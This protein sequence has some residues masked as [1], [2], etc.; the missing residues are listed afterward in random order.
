MLHHLNLTVNNMNLRLYLREIH[1]LKYYI[2]AI[3]I[4][5][6]SSYS[7]YFFL[8]EKLVATLGSEDNFFE[9]L[10]ALC[11]LGASVIFWKL[12]RMKKN[13]FFLALAFVFFVGF[14]EEISWGQR[15]IGFKTPEKI[16]KI[17]V[18]QEFNIHNLELLNTKDISGASK[19]GFKRLLE[20]NFLFKVFTIVF[21]IF[22]PLAAFHLGFVKKTARLLK[23]PVPPFSLGIFFFGNW[24]IF[25]F[26]LSFILPSGYNFQYYDS[27][28]EIFEFVSSAI[29]L[30][31]AIFFFNYSN[32]D[33]SLDI[34]FQLSGEEPQ[35]R[36]Y[37]LRQG[38]WKTLAM[39]GIKL[40]EGHK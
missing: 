23:V 6:F 18:Q 21:G 10:T 20:V 26:L 29:V 39:L 9:W 28:T 11:F 25:R 30:A 31:T 17:N 5:I 38:L 2:L 19:H 15:L 3:A 36:A 14:G 22:L 13:L 24:L 16:E 40:T 37:P 7:V 8:D 34:K 1:H 33:S 32:F 4:I 27:D 12:F 35:S